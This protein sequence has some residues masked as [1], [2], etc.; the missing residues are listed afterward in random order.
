MKKS[1]SKQPLQTLE[2]QQKLLQ[3]VL[4]LLRKYAPLWYPE[5]LDTRLAKSVSNVE[6]TKSREPGEQNEEPRGE[7]VRFDYQRQYAV[8]EIFKT[9][10]KL[11]SL[12]VRFPQFASREYKKRKTA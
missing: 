2:K 12:R 8:V 3:D 11:C 5:E 6:C 7:H 4:F 1:T 9:S 10:A